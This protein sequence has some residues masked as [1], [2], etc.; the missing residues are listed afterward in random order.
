MEVSFLPEGIYFIY[1]YGENSFSVKK[2]L[3]I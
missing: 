2:F 1:L 3:K